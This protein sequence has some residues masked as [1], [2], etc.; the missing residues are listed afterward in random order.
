M[1]AI[2]V[3]LFI[4]QHP[5]FTNVVISDQD[6]KTPMQAIE[7]LASVGKGN[8]RIN[9]TLEKKYHTLVIY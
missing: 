4:A 1:T 2:Q 5:E 8:Y 6:D 9:D 3:I 7:W